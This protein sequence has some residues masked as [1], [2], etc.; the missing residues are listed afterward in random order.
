MEAGV[1]ELELGIELASGVKV[2]TIVVGTSS[3][4][5]TRI[6]DSTVDTMVEAGS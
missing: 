1:D 4:V 2:C 3:V 6:E 5:V